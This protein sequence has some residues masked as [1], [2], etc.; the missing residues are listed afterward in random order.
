MANKPADPN[1]LI[2]LCISEVAGNSK[3]PEGD[4][5][6]ENENNDTHKEPVVSMQPTMAC[7][8]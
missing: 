5:G 2:Q 7:K 1:K 6:F 8:F 3:K 4:G